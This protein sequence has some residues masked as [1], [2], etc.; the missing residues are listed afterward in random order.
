MHINPLVIY[1]DKGKYPLI[2]KT[3]AGHRSSSES[4]L[5]ILMLM[6][7]TDLYQV[8]ALI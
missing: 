7:N 1:L 8:K 2:L 6:T 5:Q 4:E 3:Q